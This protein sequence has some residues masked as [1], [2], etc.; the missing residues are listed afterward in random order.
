MDV[1]SQL[2]AAAALRR[3][4]T[5]THWIGGWVSPG[6]PA[7]SLVTILTELPRLEEG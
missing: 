1:S 5:G 4:V 2:H 7:R 6:C 3:G